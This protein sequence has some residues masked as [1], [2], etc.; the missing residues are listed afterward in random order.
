MVHDALLEGPGFHLSIA[1][2][3]LD[4]WAVQKHG[5][6]QLAILHQT[7]TSPDLEDACRFIRH[8]WPQTRILV[9]RGGED[10]LEDAL[11]DDRIIPN[12][13]REVLLA[14]I[15]QLTAAQHEGRNGN[16]RA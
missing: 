6:F 8:H 15:E 1:T 3:F 16:G 10:F 14:T 7:L 4:L 12:V 9:I 2:G 11:Y 5:D 13:A